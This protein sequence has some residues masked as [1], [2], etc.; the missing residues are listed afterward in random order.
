MAS[1]RSPA[2]SHSIP[3][4]AIIPFACICW[5][6]ATAGRHSLLSLFYCLC[7]S[8]SKPCLNSIL[9][10]SLSLRLHVVN[11]GVGL[12][13]L[14]VR[15]MLLTTHFAPSFILREEGVGVGWRVVNLREAETVSKGKRLLVDACATYYIYVLVG[16]AMGDGFFQR[17]VGVATGEG[18]LRT[19]YDD[20]ATVGQSALG[21]RLEG[22]TTHHYGVARG[23]LLEMLHILIDM[24]QQLVLIAYSPVV[25]YGSYDI[26]LHHDMISLKSAGM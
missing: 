18:G 16:S 3:Q 21:E 14:L 13:V 17:A 6:V 23:E 9:H 25:V 7:F 15:G 11:E 26:Y 24:K 22:A 2:A 10:S 1:R 5:C 20:V 12:V 4:S 19:A 8:L